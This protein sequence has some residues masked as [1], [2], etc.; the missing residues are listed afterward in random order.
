MLN[1]P[2]GFESHSHQ[3]AYLFASSTLGEG[4]TKK[5]PDYSGPSYTNSRN[6]IKGIPRYRSCTLTYW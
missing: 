4:D 6:S 2:R 5:E 1:P 3:T